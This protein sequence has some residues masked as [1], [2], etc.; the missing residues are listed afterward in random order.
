MMNERLFSLLSD[1]LL[2]P[3]QLNRFL[4]DL[5][6]YASEGTEIEYPGSP[7]LLDLHRSALIM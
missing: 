5:S 2:Q 6:D 7:R 3:Y 4:G 1:E